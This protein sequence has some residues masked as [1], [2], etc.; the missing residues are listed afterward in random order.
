MC[1]TLKPKNIYIVWLKLLKIKRMN[2]YLIQFYFLSY[3]I[4]TE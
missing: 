4:L 1:H 2:L 3:N